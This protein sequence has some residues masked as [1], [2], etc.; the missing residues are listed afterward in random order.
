MTE[1]E[2]R[3]LIVQHA[4]GIAKRVDIGSGFDPKADKKWLEEKLLRMLELTREMKQ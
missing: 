2:R 3:I 1:E 4:Q